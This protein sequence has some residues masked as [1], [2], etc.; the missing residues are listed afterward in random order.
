MNESVRQK[1]GKALPWCEDEFITKVELPGIRQDQDRVWDP[2]WGSGISGRRASAQAQYS[3]G[4]Q[5]IRPKKGAWLVEVRPDEELPPYCSVNPRRILAPTALD[6]ASAVALDYASALA[7]RFGSELALLYA[8]E[9]SD[10]AQ[11]SKIETE[12]LT[13]CSERV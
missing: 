11:S 12:L 10:Y 3:N 4:L 5:G 2:N 7:R 13:C 8:F 1:E 9:G 6:E